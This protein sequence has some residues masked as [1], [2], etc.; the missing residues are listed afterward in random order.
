MRGGPGAKWKLPGSQGEHKGDPCN[1]N[2][3][4][5][6]GCG[7]LCLSSAGHGGMLLIPAFTNQRNQ[8]LAITD[9]CE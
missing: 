2:I 3:L 7:S 4:S 8:G 1:L 6:A 9:Q 5:Q